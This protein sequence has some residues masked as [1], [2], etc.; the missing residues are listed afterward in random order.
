MRENCQ[1]NVVIPHFLKKA[2]LS[3]CHLKR[4]PTING[5]KKGKKS[6]GPKYREQD[7][8]RE[9]VRQAR[10]ERLYVGTVMTRMVNMSCKDVCDETGG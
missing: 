3:R 10:S 8:V 1:A 2:K 4:L 9:R 7:K 5:E 6:N